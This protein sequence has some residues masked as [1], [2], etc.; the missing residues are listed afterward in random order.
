MLISQIGYNL[1]HTDSLFWQACV[2]KKTSHPS[3]TKNLN[4]HFKFC[5]EVL[6]KNKCK[7]WHQKHQKHADVLWLKHFTLNKSYHPNYA[8]F[9]RFFTHARLC[10]HKHTEWERVTDTHAH[11]HTM[12]DYKPVYPTVMH[13]QSDLMILKN[14]PQIWYLL[15]TFKVMSHQDGSTCNFCLISMM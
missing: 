2:C 9:I 1:N 10:T 15:G 14:V 11:A 13:K 4:Y 6:R 8:G 12:T 3:P 5:R 7:I